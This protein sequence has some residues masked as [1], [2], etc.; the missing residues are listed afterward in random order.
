MSDNINNNVPSRHNNMCGECSIKY[1]YLEER[2]KALEGYD[3]EVRDTKLNEVNTTLTR[4]NLLLE[5]Q[6]KSIERV[7]NEL[8][9]SRK[10]Y[11]SS[12]K[13]KDETLQ[14][15]TNNILEISNTLESYSETQKSLQKSISKLNDRVDEIADRSKLD[16]ITIVKNGLISLFTGAV[17]CGIIYLIITN[18]K[19]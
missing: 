18:L 10:S 3:R 4:L 8:G 5:V 9:E 14:K 2:V 1:E 12:L 15:L 19:N 11:E 17:S 7:L 6:E 16:F 13:E